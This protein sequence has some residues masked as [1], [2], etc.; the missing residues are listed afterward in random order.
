VTIREAGLRCELAGGETIWT[1][2]CHKFRVEE[3][4]GWARPA[5]FASRAHWVDA[6]WPFVESLF[7]AE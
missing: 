4:A 7:T 5:G 3:V 1:E 2:A 6:E